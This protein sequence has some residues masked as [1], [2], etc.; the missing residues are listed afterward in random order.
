MTLVSVIVPC[1]NEQATIRLL[2]QA[3][4]EQTFAREQMEVVLADGMSSDRTRAEIADFQAAH[5][6]LLVRVV[7]N[8]LRTIPAGLNRAIA[9][10][11]GEI[12]LRL[13]A[14]SVPAPDYVQRCVEALQA[15]LGENV[16]GIWKILPGGP[17]WVARS[18]AA[19][20]AHPFGV[21][22]ALYRYATQSAYVDTLP[23]GAFTRATLDKVGGFDES[24]LT[25][26]DYE[27][28]T[29]IRQ[30]GGRIWLDPRIHSGYFAR[31]TMEGLA[32]QYFRYGYWKLRMLR[33]YPGTIRWRQALPPVFVLSLLG[34]LILALFWRA[35]GW[36]LLAELVLYGLVLLAGALPLALKKSDAALLG[37]IPLAIAIMHVGWG[38]GFLY[39]LVKSLFGK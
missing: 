36:L 30:Q 25:N 17:G 26:E 23:F 28:N 15:G 39:S 8:P 3:V 7:D 12:I 35:A 1:Y 38:S 11:H 5:P 4:Y 16:G 31:A 34:L 18:I 32:R 37:G 24:L 10:S 33:R 6:Q 19:A 29:R 22:D 13:D 14:H 20:A 27:L 9:D 21:G 2:L